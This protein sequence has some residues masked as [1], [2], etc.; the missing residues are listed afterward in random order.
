LPERFYWNYAT[1]SNESQT[2]DRQRDSVGS[3]VPR[4]INRGRSASVEFG[5]DSRPM[6]FLHHSFQ[7]SR[8]LSLPTQLLERVGFINF[9]RVVRWSQ[10]MD[11]RFD[12]KR[13]GSWLRPTATWNA[14]YRQNNGPELSPDLSV[15]AVDNQQQIQLAWG[16]PFDQLG[17]AAH[18]APGDTA[19]QRRPVPWRGLLARLGPLSANAALI[20]S[21]G[22]SR[23]TGAPDILYMLGLSR[24]PGFG[25][26]RPATPS[27]GNVSSDA[28][29]WRFSGRTSL[30]L[31]LGAVLATRGDISAVE[32][33][34][35]GVQD[36][37]TRIRFPDLDLTYGRIASF[38]GLGRI[39]SN[40]R[41]STRYGRSQS[42]D[43]TNR[44]PDPSAI[45]TSSDW[46]PLFEVAGDLKNGTRTQL[47]VNRRVSQ[48]ENR[49]NGRSVTT[50]RYTT[51]N[52][53]INRSYS[54]GQKV[55]ILGKET[56]VK[57]NIN[58]G[59]S[60][61]YERQSAE[62]IQQFYGVAQNQTRRDRLSVNAQGGYSFSTNVTGNLEFGFGQNRDLVRDIISRTL[63][64]EVRGQFTF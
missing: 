43:Y 14:S 46:S 22:Q 56:T 25:I 51:A 42:L 48:S 34:R 36:R 63:R 59:L 29:E 3:L 31:G 50:D 6:D 11:A 26:G 4:A 13:F 40:P 61:A 16:L 2:F 7:A 24:D 19:R 15:R 32:N 12:V 62:T 5:A 44:G 39:L 54:K 49:L 64:I 23:M 17:R 60:T 47:T 1:Q 21:S 18:P 35:N 55:N 33:D 8:N 27:F 41:I 9:G 28:S 20:T 30:D 10:S 53:S 57:S 37:H 58:L 38:V 45:S 52:F